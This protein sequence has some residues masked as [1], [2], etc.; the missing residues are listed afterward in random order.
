MSDPPRPW[1]TGDPSTRLTDPADARSTVETTFADV[2]K[3][4]NFVVFEPAWLP[5]DCRVSEV[6]LR[7]E[8]PPGR[9]GETAA[10]DL[11]QTPWSEGNPCSLR[12]VVVGD[13]RRFRIKEFLYDWAPPAASVAPLWET[14]EPEP[15]ECGDVIGW[16]GTDY[17]GNRGACVQRARTQLEVSVLEGEFGDDELLDLL[18]GLEVA[19]PGSSRPVRTAPFHALNYWVRYGYEPVAVP[20]G[21][22]DYHVAR[23]FDASFRVAPFATSAGAVTPLSPVDGEFQFDSAVAFPGAEAIELVFRN[24]ANGSDHLWILAAA[25][26]SPLAPPIPPEPSAQPAERRGAI[27]L[28][29][30]TVHYA[31][32]TEEQGAWEAFWAEAGRRYAVWAGASPSLERAGF[33]RVVESLAAP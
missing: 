33:R 21:L 17:K 7:P 30:A 32:L 23:P 16:L 29:D 24:R 6:T 9:P 5:G 25:E 20:H 27:E 4:V 10:G 1:Q 19:A 28:R 11:G 2:Q 31:A 12:A 22:W 3:S 26:Q 8:Q 13:N 14:S 18:C 15:V